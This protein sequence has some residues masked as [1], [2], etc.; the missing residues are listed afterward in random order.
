MIRIE[1]IQ[2]QRLAAETLRH[3]NVDETVRVMDVRE[4]TDGTWMVGFEDRAPYTRFPAFEIAIQQDWSLDEA[5]RELR[6]ALRTKLWIC[7]LCQ[8]RALMRRIVDREVFRVE[9]ES[10]G[11]F[12]IESSFLDYLR[13]AY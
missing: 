8:R 4:L 7:P 3:L 9:C 5:T 13:T 1:A 12:E 6:L 2:L 10:C 11:R